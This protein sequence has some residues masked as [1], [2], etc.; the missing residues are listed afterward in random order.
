MSSE[1]KIM[2]I[3]ALFLAGW[4]WSYLFIRQILFNV[5]VAKPMIKKM[6]ALQEDL[7]A[8]GAARYTTISSIVCGLIAALLLALAVFLCKT[9]YIWFLV[10]F[11]LGA[12]IAFI[13]LL[14][15][16]RPENQSMFKAFCNAYYRFIPDDELRTAF[17][18]NKTG[19]IRS[20]LK[21]M[22]LSDTVIPKIQK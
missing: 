1:L 9:K 6:R 14:R 13:M 16:V 12:I 17:Y 2:L 10:A 8:I 18:N 15:M 11:C 22:G 19:P 3:G 20:R 21:A 5:L 7:I 4:L